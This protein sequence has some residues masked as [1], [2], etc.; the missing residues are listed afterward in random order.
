MTFF[1]WSENNN[2]TTQVLYV[3][4]VIDRQTLVQIVLLFDIDHNDDGVYTY[5]C[6]S[7]GK[8]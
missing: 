6:L 4:M 7:R 5:V 8:C 3:I 2:S 1:Y